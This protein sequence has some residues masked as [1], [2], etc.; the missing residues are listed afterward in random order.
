MYLSGV[1]F[2]SRAKMWDYSR[3]RN[4]MLRFGKAVALVMAAISRY[5][6]NTDYIATSCKMPNTTPVPIYNFQC[7]FWA[8]SI[9]RYPLRHSEN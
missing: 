7:T 4:D 9:A 3:R 1:R 8:L 5:Y 6:T 2:R